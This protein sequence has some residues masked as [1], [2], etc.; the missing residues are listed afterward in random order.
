MS[1]L[2]T[3]LFLIPLWVPAQQLRLSANG[4]F[5]ETTAGEP[6]LYLGDTAW[7]LF[8]RLNR[9]EATAYLENRA[10]KGFSVIQAVV[11]AELD[12]LHSPNPYGHLPLL[13]DDPGKPNEA[14]FQHVDY[15]V[16]EAERLGLVIGMLP[17]WGD[18]FNKKW[19]VGPE[20][21]TEE[22]A[23][24]FGEFLGKRY[25]NA[26]IIWILGG[27][28]SPEEAE[29]YTIIRAMAQGL[30]AGDEGSHL[31]TYHPMGG[32]KSYE[33]F[34]EDQWID[35][36][37]F[38]S[39]HGSSGNKNYQITTEGYQLSPTK[40]VLDGEPCYED[41]PINW[42]SANG[43]FDE[44]DARR[45]AWWSF[46]SGA[47]GH[48][49]GNHNIWQ[50]WQEGRAPISQARTSWDI[51]MN[52]PGAFQIGYMGIFLR[53]Y[54]WQTL[55]P[56]QG[57]IAA[58]PNTEGK[59]IRAAKAGDGS[60]VMVYA[61]WGSTFSLHVDQLAKGKREASWFNPRMG[62]IIEL[63]D[64]PEPQT[65]MTFD[66]PADEEEGNDWVLVISVTKP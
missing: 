66:P 63:H 56:A 44:F 58:G 21:F 7:E 15:I 49:Y 33:Y 19:G 16:Q 20:I 42:N 30:A 3:F 55:T 50:M 47:C 40:P 1:R 11:L 9:E 38:Q 59:D 43:W 26:A 4:R 6:F 37:M 12:G 35:F 25:R 41:H 13:N 31:M 62:E 5:L 8:H 18:K 45:A 2:L 39:G 32:N 48:T 46:L 61:P 22:N 17:T 34:G 51:A 36:H 64:L 60:L 14:Y 53:K 29:D 57:M 65:N 23:K 10:A 54:A 28:R 27:D 24:T 52:Y